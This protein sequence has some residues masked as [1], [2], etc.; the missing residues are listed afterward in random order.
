MPSCLLAAGGLHHNGDSDSGLKVVGRLFSLDSTIIC[1]PSGRM[2]AARAPGARHIFIRS[3]T[4]FLYLYGPRDFRPKTDG[5][6]A[7]RCFIIYNLV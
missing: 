1:I 2:I 6:H 5:S 3:M 4:D 7:G